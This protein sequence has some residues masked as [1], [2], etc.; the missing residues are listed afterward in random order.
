L[1]SVTLLSV[2]EACMPF[3]LST[4]YTRLVNLFFAP[5]PVLL[6]HLVNTACRYAQR[7]AKQRSARPVGADRL[8][9]DSCDSD[10]S[11]LDARRRMLPRIPVEPG[12]TP[13]ES[14]KIRC[15]EHFYLRFFSS[16]SVFR[17]CIDLLVRLVTLFAFGDY[18]LRIVCGANGR[19]LQ[20]LN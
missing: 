5:T 14:Y 12:D 9:I 19:S 3:L 17:Y 15:T 18:P 20:L 16:R 13:Q 10:C 7:R 4:G 1:P 6:I 11:C 2:F 8:R